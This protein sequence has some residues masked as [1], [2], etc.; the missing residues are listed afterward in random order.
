MK[1]V[2]YGGGNIGRGFL[3]QLLCESGYETV[4]IDINQAMIDQINKE[5]KYPVKIVCNEY[6]KEIEITNVRAVH[7]D[8][9]P[10]EIATAD[11]MF[12][13]AGVKV[14]PYI[15]PVIKK[16]LDMRGGKGLDIII[17]ENLIAAD[18]YLKELI[19][20][21]TD[22]IGFVEASVGRMVPVMTDE[23]REGNM[24]KVWVEPFCTLP[25]DKD[26]F[27]NPIPEIKGM[28]PSSPF[29]YYI[30]SKLYLHNMG[31]AIAA[32][33]GMK[34]GYEYIWQSMEDAEIFDLVKRAMYA[35]S[36]AL[37]LEHGK[38]KAEVIAYA[39]DL[40]FRFK[41]KFLGDTTKRVGRETSRKL[42]PNDRLLGALTLCQKH[43]IKAD[44]IKEGIV[45]A[46]DFLYEA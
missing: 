25:V 20:P 38:D 3:G 42:M 34:K 14:L 40:L 21:E 33:T 44:A 17:C 46:L 10:Q 41:N 12:T 43:G 36:E 39:D 2:V 19:K 1:A 18:K 26:A 32:Y 28:V 15:A 37:A 31:H 5:G 8:D 13:S 6:Q 24:C 22:N 7:A 9:A 30:Q 23:M 35:S 4:F 29:E 27:K 45:A 11:I 16:G